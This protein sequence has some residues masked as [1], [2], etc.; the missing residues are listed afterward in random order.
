VKDRQIEAKVQALVKAK[1]SIPSP[2]EAL[3]GLSDK[4]LAREGK[5]LAEVL[6]EFL[7]FASNLPV[8]SHNAEFDYGFLRAACR[9]LKLPLFSNR[10]VDTLALSRRLID[11]VKNYKL[12]TLLDYFE[13]K[14]ECMHRSI[15]DCLTTKQLYEKLIKL[16]Q[17]SV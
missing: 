10:Y 12:E 14:V 17:E 1:A 4:V 15:T 2:I 16:E 11:D 5:E 9:C 13:I 7:K 6:P 3:T 8:V